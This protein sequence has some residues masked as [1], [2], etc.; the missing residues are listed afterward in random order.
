MSK[1]IM[2]FNLPSDYKKILD[3]WSFSDKL[4]K[5]KIIELLISKELHYRAVA[6]D[7]E[8]GIQTVL[9]IHEAPEKARI[10]GPGK[11]KCNPKLPKLCMVCWGENK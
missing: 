6:K 5:S 3:E 4:S 10:W 2:S 11:N 7:K 8:A 1:S 9:E